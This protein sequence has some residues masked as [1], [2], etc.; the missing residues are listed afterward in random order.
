MAR[1]LNSE[2]AKMPAVQAA[3]R[4]VAEQIETTAKALAAGHGGLSADIRVIAPNAYDYD[5]VL[6]HEAAM[7]IEF[8]H[9]D[10]VF[11]SGWVPGLHIMRDAARLHS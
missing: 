3:V 2:V 5:V 6:D 11:G 8:G 4:A 7:S 10:A 9:Q 1:S